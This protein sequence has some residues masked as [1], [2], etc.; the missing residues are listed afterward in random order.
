MTEKDPP[1]DATVKPSDSV[2]WKEASRMLDKRR[3]M[4]LSF[5]QVLGLLVGGRAIWSLF[6]LDW[7]ALTDNLQ[8]LAVLLLL[9]M[10]ILLG[11]RVH[12]LETRG[13][14]VDVHAH[15]VPGPGFEV[16]AATAKPPPVPSRPN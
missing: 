6:D 11:A 12:H 9:R 7:A 4:V 1:A 8:T 2:T 15:I 10:V 14:K 13:M 16:R 3:A 5:I